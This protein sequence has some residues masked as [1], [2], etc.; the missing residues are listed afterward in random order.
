M[1]V[2]ENTHILFIEPTG[3]KSEPIKDSLTN[4][5]SNAMLSAT[6]NPYRVYKGWH[7]CVCGEHSDNKEWVLPNG[8]II[9]SL[10]YHYIAEHRD[11]VPEFELEKIRNL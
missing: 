3:K 10:A 9:N 8:Q 4:K 5:V 6:F 11:E 2:T 7:T 1:I